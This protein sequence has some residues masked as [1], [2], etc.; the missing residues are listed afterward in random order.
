MNKKI[1]IGLA[2]GLSVV[3]TACAGKNVA[4]DALLD[5]SLCADTVVPMEASLD[6]TIDGLKGFLKFIGDE[7]VEIERFDVHDKGDH[8]FIR[9]VLDNDQAGATYAL[10]DNKN[11]TMCEVKEQVYNQ[12][13]PKF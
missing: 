8:S 2:V 9:L 11:E 6:D 3:F 5:N 1:K 13:K 10:V 12:F 4:K 7:D